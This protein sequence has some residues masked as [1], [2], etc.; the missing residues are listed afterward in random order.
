LRRGFIDRDQWVQ[1]RDRF[2][3]EWLEHRDDVRARNREVEGGPSYYVVRRH[4]IGAHLLGTVSYLLKTGSMTT[5]K[6][7][8]VLGVKPKNVAEL[9]AGGPKPA[10]A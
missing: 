1:L 5:V 8:K 4:R 2:R 10:N 6:A 9:L 7:V 3:A